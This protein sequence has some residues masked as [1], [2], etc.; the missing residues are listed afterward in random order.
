M[1]LPAITAASPSRSAGTPGEE[2]Q[3]ADDVRF[4]LP[5][6]GYYRPGKLMPVEFAGGQGRTITLAADGAV[7]TIVNSAADGVAAWLPERDDLNTPLFGQALHELTDDQRLVASER[8]QI[9]RDL[10]PGKTIVEIRLDSAE[11]L[12]GP[13]AAWQTLDAI[14]LDEVPSQAKVAAL[15]AGGTSVV[16]GSADK[17]ADGLPWRQDGDFWVIRSPSRLVG[18]P[19]DAVYDSL[20]AWDEQT[21]D[22]FRLRI[23]LVGV[24]V[25]VGFLAV[26]LWRSKWAWAAAILWA[27][28][29]AGG[30]LA[31]NHQ[32]YYVVSAEGEIGI[33]ATPMEVDRW[34]FW[35]GVK[36]AGVDVPWDGK[37]IAVPILPQE[38]APEVVLRCGPDGT[39]VEWH[40]Q[41]RK[42]QTIALAAEKVESISL[43]PT[44][45][46]VESPLQ[47][48]VDA[49]YPEC[50]I[51]GQSATPVGAT[52]P[53]IWLDANISRP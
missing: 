30:I 2:E 45:G 27:G 17:P 22:V 15:L 8:D 1:A 41:L 7:T 21:P 51:K 48:M 50:A 52:W 49:V 18:R 43:P 37:S 39:P 11:A 26:R 53:T 13:V 36:T 31:W 47:G 10:F 40:C 23:V 35:R 5:L 12:L 20:A 24:I 4:S 19:T 29:C 42:G 28:I 25:A 3:R 14:V 33:D 46:D 6:Q 34:F 38:D 9:P 32:H 44:S 16:V